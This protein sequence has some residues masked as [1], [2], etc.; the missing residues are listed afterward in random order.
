MNDIIN[1]PSSSSN[2]YSKK[3]YSGKKIVFFVLFGSISIFLSL[4]VLRSFIQIKPATL[5]IL[6]KTLDVNLIDMNGN[7]VSSSD[8]FSGHISVVHIEESPC[9]DLCIKRTLEMEGVVSWTQPVKVPLFVISLFDENINIDS[10]KEKGLKENFQDR[11]K[12]YR[13]A[14]NDIKALKLSLLGSDNK[15]DL[16][17]LDKNNNIR[18]RYKTTNKSERREL[19]LDTR[20]LAEEYR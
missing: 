13:V 11:W 3:L 7:K 2:Y 6:G 9:D 18:Y 16:S 1:S 10:L 12:I 5:P 14:K 4:F 20:M 8:V 15:F 17:I 19:L